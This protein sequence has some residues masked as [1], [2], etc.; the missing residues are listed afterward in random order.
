M[1]EVFNVFYLMKFFPR[2]LIT[3]IEHTLGNSAYE[4]PTIKNYRLLKCR[5]KN[6]NSV[7]R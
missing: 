6:D 2:D 3:E 7:S 5:L 1:A 4:H